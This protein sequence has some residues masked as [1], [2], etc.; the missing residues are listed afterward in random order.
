MNVVSGLLCITLL[1][2]ITNE[3]K[4]DTPDFDMPDEMG[5]E[6]YLQQ[7]F[8]N[9]ETWIR[10][11]PTNETARVHCISRD[12]GCLIQPDDFIQACTS[13]SLLNP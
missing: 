13:R 7:R 9:P 2:D 4:H 6:R 8:T 3:W 10:S 12:S 1:H 11:D 5:Q